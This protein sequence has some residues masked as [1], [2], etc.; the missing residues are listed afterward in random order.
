MNSG[1]GRLA[2]KTP[3][4]RCAVAISLLLFLAIA[5]GQSLLS[6]TAVRSYPLADHG[7]LQLNVPTA[8]QDAVHQQSSGGPPTLE[9]IASSGRRF[10]VVLTPL[11]PAKDHDL[12]RAVQG[13]ADKVQPDVVEKTLDLRM[14]RGSDG[15]GYYFFGTDR[16]P[17]PDEFKYITQGILRVSDIALGFTILTNDDQYAVIRDS[18][19]LVRTAVHIGGEA[20]P[21]G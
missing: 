17:K 5:Y 11:W 21:S 16:A 9:F 4:F 20:A 15:T 13:L 8:W 2:G 6:P 12:H 14:M 19:Q 7:A 1:S 10:E 18:L 3:A